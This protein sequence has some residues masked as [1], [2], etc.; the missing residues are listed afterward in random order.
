MAATSNGK[1]SIVFFGKHVSLGQCVGGVWIFLLRRFLQFDRLLKVLLS[2]GSYCLRFNSAKPAIFHASDSSGNSAAIALASLALRQTASAA[3]A[4]KREK[5]R[6]PSSLPARVHW[7][8]LRLLTG[9]L[10]MT[11]VSI[12]L[13]TGFTGCTSSSGLFEFLRA[14]ELCLGSGLSKGSSAGFA[15][16]GAGFTRRGRL[17]CATLSPAKLRTT[18]IIARNCLK[19]PSIIRI[20]LG[21]GLRCG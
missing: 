18:K 19:C 3:G 20:P 2:A 13:P 16:G 8:V 4:D 1:R 10:V 14:D 21:R 7:S 17:D 11:G 15:G 12:A 6:W 5:C 9:S